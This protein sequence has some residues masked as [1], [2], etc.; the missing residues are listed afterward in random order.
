MGYTK[1]PSVKAV[2]EDI[3]E[4]L[5]IIDKFTGDID[6]MKKE[7]HK[8][9]LKKST[10]GKR[11]ERNSVYAIAFPTLRRLELIQNKGSDVC[12]SSDGKTLLDIYRNKGELEYR[13]TFAKILIRVDNEKAHVIENLLVLD[14]EIIST[15]TLV[16]HLKDNGIDTSLKD[17]RLRRWLR[18]LRYADF[19]DMLDG[20][21]KIN[22]FQIISIQESKKPVNFKRFVNTLLEEY[23]RIR[24]KNKGNIYVKIPELESG[25]CDRLKNNFTTFDFSAYIKK[26]KN[27]KIKGKKIMFSKPGA[28]EMGGIKI[29]GIY[30]YYVSVYEEGD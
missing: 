19:I 25:V 23:D 7:I 1:I 21:T 26:L 15:K 12:L 2:P 16:S 27:F 9:L 5:K 18:L 4:F 6:N 29:N 30:Y 28:R 11:N 14:E 13:K 8:Y 10:R 20:K 24:I 3:I 22:K 17:D